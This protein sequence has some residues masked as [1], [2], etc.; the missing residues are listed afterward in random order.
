MN[1]TKIPATIPGIGKVK[2]LIEII[3]TRY[4]FLKPRARSIPYSYV[5]PSTSDNIRLKTSMEAII[6]RKTII[7]KKVASVK[8][9]ILEVIPN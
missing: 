7:E 2:L 9:F 3:D 6:D 5:L 4:D 1:A 8:L